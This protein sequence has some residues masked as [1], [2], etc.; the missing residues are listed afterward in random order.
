MENTNGLSFN[1]TI[2]SDEFK[3][4]MQEASYQFKKLGDDASKEGTKIDSSLKRVG[5][6]VGSYFA[7]QQVQQF[8]AQIIRVRSEIER[9]Q[10]SFKTLAGTE[11]GGQL[12]EDI[13]Q[14]ATSTPLLLND[15]ASAAQT[16]LG[17][18]IEAGKILPN[19][20]AIGDISM[21]DSQKLQSLA[22]SFSQMT[23]TGKLMGQDLLQMIN[24]GFN[25][26]AEISRKTGKSIGDLKDEMEKGAISADMVREAFISATS[27][28]GK[29]NGMLEAQS[30]TISGAYS[31]LQGAI[32]DAFNRIGENMQPI[33]LKTIDGLTTIAKNFE[34]V[35]KVI[36][37]VVEVVGLYKAAEIASIAITKAH[38]VAIVAQTVAQK[39]LNAVMMLNPY[40]AVTA[41]VVAL[42]AAIYTLS[43]HSTAQE[44]AQKKVNERLEENAKLEQD[45]KS[46]IEACIRVIKDEFA[47]TDEQREALVSLKAEYPEIFTKYDL[48]ALKLA[49]ILK[50]K[51]QIAE[52]DSKRNSQ[53]LDDNISELD[54]EIKHLTW[55]LSYSKNKYG[56]GGQ[57][58]Q[59]KLQQKI[60]EKK[61]ERKLLLQKRGKV[62]G[63]QFMSSL[64]NENVTQ[65]SL[66]KYR[67]KLALIV[68]GKKDEQSIRI[69]L[70]V[71]V[72]GKTEISKE[73]VMSVSKIKEFIAGIDNEI[74]TR[75]APK[76]INAYN[77]ALADYKK[78]QKELNDL[79]AKSKTNLS[80][81]EVTKLNEDIKNKEAELKTAK[82][83]LESY[84]WSEQ[85]TTSKSKS[86]KNALTQA[87]HEAQQNRLKREEE[88]RQQ[89]LQM[90]VDLQDKQIAAMEDGTNKQ[91]AILKKKHEDEKRALADEYRAALEAERNRQEQEFNDNEK[92]RKAKER[93]K[94]VAKYFNRESVT[95]D[96]LPDDVQKNFADQ[97][98]ALSET[99][100]RELN[101]FLKE[102]Q[103]AWNIYLQE[104]GTYE[105]QRLAI[106][107]E[108]NEKIKRARA[109][110]DSAEVFTL[111]AQKEQK[112]GEV[113]SN[114]LREEIDWASAFNDGGQQAQSIIEQTLQKINDYISTSEFRGLNARDKESILDARSNLESMIPRSLI[115]SI[116]QA[117]IAQQELQHALNNLT[118]AETQYRAALAGAQLAEQNLQTVKQ[119]GD[120]VAIKAATEFRDRMQENLEIAKKNLNTSRAKASNANDK[121][122]SANE[123]QA[124][125]FDKI[126][127]AMQQ[128]MSGDLMGVFQGI[129]TLIPKDACGGQ[130]LNGACGGKA[131]GI[132]GIIIQAVQMIAD[133]GFTRCL[134]SITSMVTKATSS[135][136]NDMFVNGTAW[137]AI[138]QSFLDAFTM[139][140]L[141]CD[142]LEEMRNRIE[143]A[144]EAL[145]QFEFVL[146]EFSNDLTNN[147][148][149]D[150]RSNYNQAKRALNAQENLYQEQINAAQQ[151]WLGCSGDDITEYLKE[152][153]IPQKLASKGYNQDI[154]K[155]TANQWYKMRKYDP[156][157][158]TE[159][160]RAIEEAGQDDE[161]LKEFADKILENM[162]ALAEIPQ[163]Q[164][165]LKE[166][167]NE[168]LVGISFDGLKDKFKGVISD[169]TTSAE[170][171][172]NAF[173]EIINNIAFDRLTDKYKG[174]IEQIYKKY[175]EYAESG[176]GLDQYEIQKLNQMQDSL[177]EKVLAD[178]KRLED[179]GLIRDTSDTGTDA[180]TRSSQSLTKEQG[181]VISGRMT[182]IQ[183]AV[184]QQNQLLISQNATLQNIASSQNGMRGIL[185]SYQDI[186]YEQ[187]SHL[188]DISQ[189]TKRLIAIEQ[190]LSDIKSNTSRL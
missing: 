124:K 52:F 42:G 160:Q 30:K 101:D 66:E 111:E 187:N 163:K 72:D 19:L 86:D 106:E 7:F 32:D 22:L 117:K 112:I 40:V 108:F 121:A 139:G 43:D 178:R 176:G 75:N 156:E 48:E 127:A 20:K 61:A 87:E 138:G 44:R 63:E 13:K 35:G 55:D 170:D 119:G 50:L 39:A 79:R 34:D 145:E 142:N 89:I 157:L 5:A 57:A 105:Q 177:T 132:I 125:S 102:G 154:S 110:G 103:N 171:F 70:P 26:L 6:A 2:N 58:Q 65:Q 90:E 147:K 91:L 80:Q 64:P 167:L 18:G 54:D 67:K 29:F 181:E 189:N 23:A 4:Q 123:E 24:A 94:Y 78:A 83:K 100:K 173:Q 99:Q 169:M 85:K 49:D 60:N 74:K 149:V 144:T 159:I 148:A 95:Y 128:F 122:T 186:L 59:E 73:T 8:A 76:N 109:N 14:Y 84:G 172:A 1:I 81:R 28:G 162:D 10:V 56:H 45:R 36:L 188:K 12:F 51:K 130:G 9:L 113:S 114:Q 141:K 180:S 164:E 71:I 140:L 97:F 165:E 161:A 62:V 46:K 107:A 41:A 131:G 146:K 182:Y 104:Y 27:E 69:K 134:Q 53:D 25:P 155:I 150:S 158:Y 82:E 33:I 77:N 152:A 168:K 151:A 175:A 166:K 93:D 136:I 16:M 3:R 98:E 115:D 68:K 135:V 183:M 21:G 88:I 15:L 116:K 120:E 126:S 153:K 38:T 133:K 174:E 17:F 96:L 179:A 185:D 118:T 129:K 137:T 92:I 143:D 11:V 47:A 31:N 190:T 37:T 184:T